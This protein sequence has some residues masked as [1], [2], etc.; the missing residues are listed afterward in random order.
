ADPLYKLALADLLIEEARIEDGVAL[1]EET[2][3]GSTHAGAYYFRLGNTLSRTGCQQLSGRFYRK[4]LDT[5]PDNPFYKARC[6]ASA[7]SPKAGVEISGST[8]EL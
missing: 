8:K 3:A 4:A 6:V 7:D 2:A 5:D 1:Y